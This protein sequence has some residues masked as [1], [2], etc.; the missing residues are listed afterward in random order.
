MRRCV[1]LYTGL[2]SVMRRRAGCSDRQASS[3]GVFQNIKQ[4]REKEKRE[5]QPR[6]ALGYMHACT[7]NITPAKELQR[8]NATGGAGKL[9][10]YSQPR[11]THW[12]YPSLCTANGPLLSVRRSG[13]YFCL[14]HTCDLII[15]TAFLSQ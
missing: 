1:D 12:R 14:R 4:Q 9:N 15:A 3:L 10:G 6:P 13:F 7:L 8:R 2:C 11:T 5:R